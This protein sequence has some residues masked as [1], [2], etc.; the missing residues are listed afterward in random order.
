MF[1]T[2][3]TEAVQRLK[4]TGSHT[5]NPKS[6]T[7]PHC[8]SLPSCR[9]VRACERTQIVPGDPTCQQVLEAEQLASAKD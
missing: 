6:E 8:P 4:E 7:C 1:E 3:P 2:Q 9:Q 5:I